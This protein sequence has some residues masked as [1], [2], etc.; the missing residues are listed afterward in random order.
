MYIHLYINMNGCSNLVVGVKIGAQL[1]VPNTGLYV[2]NLFNTIFSKMENAQIL[3]WTQTT[4]SHSWI[5]AINSSAATGLG[6]TVDVGGVIACGDKWSQP[7]YIL[8]GTIVTPCRCKASM[9]G[10]CT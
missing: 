5:K 8:P 3:V 7:Q 4:F 1:M 6:S 10:W 9:L 2:W